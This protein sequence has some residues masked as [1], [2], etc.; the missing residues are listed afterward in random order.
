MHVSDVR[1]CMDARSEPVARRKILIF[2]EDT[3]LASL[4]H[5]LLHREGFDLSII[6]TE[7]D[8][9]DHIQAQ[10]PPELLF[11]NHKWLTDDYPPVIQR[12]QHHD[13]WQDVAIILLLNYFDED[14]IE[15]ANDMGVSDYLVQPIEPGVLL[16]IIQ[17][18]IKS[19]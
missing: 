3:F 8:A 1:A 16:D 19:K 10:S 5:L 17:K 2:E 14:I 11:V 9:L 6:T 7:A 12:M 13:G 4:M 15:H 18:H